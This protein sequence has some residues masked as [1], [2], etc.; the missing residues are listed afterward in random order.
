MTVTLPCPCTF[1]EAACQTLEETLPTIPA[2]TLK[3]VRM[4][5][6]GTLKNVKV[7]LMRLENS[8]KPFVVKQFPKATLDAATGIESP[9]NEIHA[10]L[11]M[12]GKDL[13]N[14]AK[15]YFA[16]Q[17]ENNVY[18]STE[19]CPNGDLWSAVTMAG[20]FQDEEMLREVLLQI[21][22]GVQSLHRLGVA[23]RDLSLENLVVAEDGD[24]RI[25]DLAQAIMVREPICGSKEERLCVSEAHGAPGKEQFRGPELKTGAS[26]LAT[27]VDSFAIGIICYALIAGE[28]PKHSELFPAEEAD[29]GYCKGL[30]DHLQKANKQIAEQI[31]TD[32]LD[33][34]E[35]LLAPNPELRLSVEEAL[36]HPFITG[37]ASCDKDEDGGASDSTAEITSSDEGSC[38]D[39]AD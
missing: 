14:V 3:K 17:D 37:S 31:S 32:C 34:M 8:R 13:P 24:I 18:L 21:L 23:H 7:M 12:R 30:Y 2:G 5:R 28:Y 6:E 19:F 39:R 15:T 27:K 38:G 25:I 33:L 35:K 9:R 11:A 29:F 16:V 20:R 10:A 36:I 22:M 1:E 26:Y 4:L